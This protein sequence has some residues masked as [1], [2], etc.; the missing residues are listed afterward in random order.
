MII[1]TNP[2]ETF[3]THPKLM[4]DIFTGTKNGSTQT[5]LAEV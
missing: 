3:N 5:I 4:E 1:Q 2:E